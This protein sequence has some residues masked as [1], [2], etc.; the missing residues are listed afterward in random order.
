MANR[1]VSEHAG[2]NGIGIYAIMLPS[3]GF[4]VAHFHC[5]EQMFISRGAVKGNKHGQGRMVT[6][7]IP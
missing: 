5:P 7:C 2:I 1:I 6:A 4:S 3:S